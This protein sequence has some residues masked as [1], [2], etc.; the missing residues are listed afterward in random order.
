MSKKLGIWTL[1][2]LC[3]GNMIG[4]GVFMIPASLASVGTISLVSWVIT[5]IGTMFIALLFVDLSRRYPVSGGPV[6]YCQHAYGDFIAFAIAYLYWIAWSVT[7][8]AM[9]IT[10]AGY[11]GELIPL[12][13]H[14]WLSFIVKAG[15]IWL[16]VGINILGVRKSGVFQIVTTII[17]IIPLVVV[18]IAGLFFI[19]VQNYFN[20]VNL[21]DKSNFGAISLALTF[22]IWAYIGFESS[23]IPAGEV[24][25][26]RDIRRATIFGIIV[27]AI[28]YILGSFTLMGMIP[29]PQLEHSNAP[30][31]DAA[32]QIFGPIGGVLVS[33]GAVISVLG[34]LNGSILVQVHSAM[35]ASKKRLFNP[36]FSELGRFGTPVKGF[37]TSATVS[38]LLL[39]FTVNQGFLDQFNL[40]V[41]LSAF[42]FLITYFVVAA[43][44]LSSLVTEKASLWVSARRWTVCLLGIIYSFWTMFSAGQVI[45]FYGILLFFTA[46]PLYALMR[47]SELTV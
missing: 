47:K 18:A 17:K 36:F 46:F 9:S 41:L 34:V 20:Y 16:V 7:L 45:V 22:T 43:G 11:V 37:V 23:T 8:A 40:I 38:T 3:I 35:A 10:L 1:S 39:L 6:I 24:E 26:P 42:A 14:Q 33:I 32:T 27:T 4:A 19:D 12:L 25:N 44:Y 15:A 31:A 21:T 13:K 29:T 5:S 30:Y 28:I 2:A